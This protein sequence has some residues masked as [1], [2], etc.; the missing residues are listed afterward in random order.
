MTYMHV[1]I[2]QPSDRDYIKHI[3]LPARL[4]QDTEASFQGINTAKKHP[5]ILP[6]N[7][8]GLLIKS[9]PKSIHSAV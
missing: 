1:L 7:T 6:M 3:V 8:S 2:W 5:F 4:I 9:W